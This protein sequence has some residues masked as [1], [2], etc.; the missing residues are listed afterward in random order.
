MTSGIV[1]CFA[2]IL[3][4]RLTHNWW[5]WATLFLPGATLIVTG[6]IVILKNR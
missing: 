2:S 1:G 3:M 5:G 6:W 4:W